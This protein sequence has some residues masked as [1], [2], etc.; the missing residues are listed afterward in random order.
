MGVLASAIAR[1]YWNGNAEWLDVGA[2]Q[3]MAA[4][5]ES[6]AS[7]RE[8]RVRNLPCGNA[9]DIMTLEGLTP[10]VYPECERSLGERLFHDLDRHLLDEDFG[11][12]FARLNMIASDASRRADMSDVYRAFDFSGVAR[13][14]VIPRWWDRS[15]SRDRS[16]LDVSPVEPA[17]RR[18][19]GMVVDA[20]VSFDGVER[21]ERVESGA[22]PGWLNLSL[23]YVYDYDARG[24]EF[25]VEVVQ[26]YEDGFEYAR[27]ALNLSAPGGTTGWNERMVVGASPSVRWAPGRH[28]IYVYDAGRKVAEVS[29][30]VNGD[31]SS[32]DES[33]DGVE[34]ARVVSVRAHLDRDPDDGE[35]TEVDVVFSEPVWVK[36][37]VSVY[38]RG[39]GALMCRNRVD[40]D[41]HIDDCPSSPEDASR[42][43]SGCST[44]RERL[45]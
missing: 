41:P 18:I 1:Y 30:R 24:N 37:L 39:R 34:S 12:G 31:A 10:S 38:V 14:G 11:L 42:L 15:V 32:P 7:G 9:R 33:G 29:Y 5:A 6:S 28:W 17:L 22:A 8:L 25:E 2:A 21:V 36:G 3:Y 23:R 13:E 44:G 27:G 16:G 43:R 19:N 20:Y 26:M 45:L 35:Q 4:V 40:S